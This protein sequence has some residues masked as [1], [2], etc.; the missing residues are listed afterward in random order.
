MIARI[1][2]T[3]VSSFSVY[4]QNIISS[5]DTTQYA[6]KRFSLQDLV[7]LQGGTGSLENAGPLPD[8]E[9]QA[10]ATKT[11]TVDLPALIAAAQKAAA[12][13]TNQKITQPPTDIISKFTN[14]KAIDIDLQAD[15]NGNLNIANLP[16]L[17]AAKTNNQEEQ[18][19]LS[20]S[21]LQNLATKPQA[22]QEHMVKEEINLGK[23]KVELE[24]AGKRATHYTLVKG[25]DGGLNLVP[26][27]EGSP[28]KFE[29]LTPKGYEEK[30][31]S[32]QQM[33]LTTLVS[34]KF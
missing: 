34:I 14:N 9:M 30:G 33:Q 17:L 11:Q 24:A 13:N 12:V 18:H 19:S 31:N 23:E 27:V 25:P 15:K 29:V 22:E 32:R 2:L 8:Q 6:A 20:L 16:D 28:S 1:L 7:G 21:D 5:P 26:V 4:S 10:T 3:L